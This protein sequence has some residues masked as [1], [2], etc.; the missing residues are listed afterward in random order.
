MLVAAGVEEALFNAKRPAALFRARHPLQQKYTE[1][2]REASGADIA[3]V[4]FAA[5]G[6]GRDLPVDA[7]LERASERSRAPDRCKSAYNL[8]LKKR[9]TQWRLTRKCTA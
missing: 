2:S 7:R 5:H 9:V 1:L 8:S 4:Y 3:V 6:T